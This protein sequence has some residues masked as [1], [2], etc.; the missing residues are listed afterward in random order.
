MG[1]GNYNENT[2]LL[3]TDLSLMTA[4][5]Q[6]GAEAAHIFHA[7]CTDSFVTESDHMLI[8]PRCLQNRILEFIDE[9]IEHAKRGEPAYVGF[10]LNALTDKIIIE[11]LMEASC[12]GVEIDLVVRGACCLVAGIPGVT[13]H[14]TVR[15][16]VGRYLEH[17]RLYILGTPER[18]RVYLGSADLMT[19][20]TLRR[21]EVAIQVLDPEIR[22]RILAMFRL[23]LA[24]NVKARIQQPDGSYVLATPGENP[25]VNAQMT[26]YEEAYRKAA[27]KETL[28]QRAASRRETKGA[29]T[30]AKPKRKPRTRKE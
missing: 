9:E 13:E 16:I 5:P 11:K 10:K 4:N 8:A 14:I 18:A 12:A 29:K 20:N 23:Y 27:E 24:D 19:R 21:V 30:P 6:I 1:T 25:P 15:S 2:S 22:E 26:L 17:S 7:L 28:R 3:Y